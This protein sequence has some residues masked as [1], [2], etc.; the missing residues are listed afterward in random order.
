MKKSL[1]KDYYKK[2]LITGSLLSLPRNLPW[3]L[4]AEGVLLLDKNF[5]LVA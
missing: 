3:S 2:L 5:N 1:K 4:L